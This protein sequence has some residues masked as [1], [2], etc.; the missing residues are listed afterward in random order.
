MVRPQGDRLLTKGE[1]GELGHVRMD[2]THK[3]KQFTSYTSGDFDLA[4]L[5]DDMC[6]VLL[7]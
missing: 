4:Y 2:S 6:Y 5:G 1:H 3:K 7:E